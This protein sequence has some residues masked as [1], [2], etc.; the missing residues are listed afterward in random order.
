MSVFIGRRN[1]ISTLIDLRYTIHEHGK[2]DLPAG[3]L[4]C[5]SVTGKR[6]VSY[7]GHSMGTTSFLAMCSTAS[8]PVLDNIAVAILLAPVVEP[9]TMTFPLKH[10]APLAAH[11]WFAYSFESVG[12][13]E[14]LPNWALIRKLVTAPWL[15][16]V[17]AIL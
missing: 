14:F 15:Q 13:Q 16:A 2:L 8:A 4:K 11:P 12:V 17:Y 3:L 7:I 5:L 1:L 6:R 9:Y 10:V